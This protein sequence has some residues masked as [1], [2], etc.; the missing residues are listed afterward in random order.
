MNRVEGKNA[1]I[2]GATAGIGQACAHALAELGVHLVLTG[3][4][5]K[6]LEEVAAALVE[7]GADVRTYALDVRDRA[8]VAD[9]MVWL[10]QNDWT[11][12]ILVNNAGLARGLDRIQEG[13]H[14]DWDEMI[15]TNVK[16]LLNMTRAVLP[17]MV[18]RD[19]G[20]IVNIGSIAGRIV[21]P[22]GNVYNATKFAVR[23]LT[24]ATNIDLV[25]TSV[26]ASS[27]DPGLVETE[28]S[29]VR[30]RG[31][32]SRADAVYE[33]IDSLHPEDIADAVAYVVNTPLHV[34]VQEIL[35]MPTVQ[36]SPYVV[37]RE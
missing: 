29:L 28:F 33:G 7:G 31:D 25:G 3:R 32:A 34:T 19:A 18:Q 20:H 27:V 5:E 17:G 2:T 13:S 35:V 6:R 12:D 4:R 14:D 16:G 22:R 24:Q 10:D 9:F 8:A 21:Y 11:P 1:I 36:R 26:R 37:D 15:D 30:F 23:A